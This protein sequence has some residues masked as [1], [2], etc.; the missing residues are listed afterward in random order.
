LT[1]TFCESARGRERA[2]ECPITV[3]LSNNRRKKDLHS[4]KEPIIPDLQPEWISIPLKTAK[5]VHE[6]TQP[7]SWR[8]PPG[9]RSKAVTFRCGF[10][11][12]HNL[13]GGILAWAD[14]IDPTMPKY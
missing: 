9:V 3:E 8:K 2:T 4:R 14:K 1:T 5:R 10:K 13:T 6:L 12:V 7:R 11:K